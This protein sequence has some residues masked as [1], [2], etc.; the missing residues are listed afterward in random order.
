MTLLSLDMQL[1]GLSDGSL[2]SR[3]SVDVKVLD[4]DHNVKGKQ[5]GSLP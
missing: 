2:D 4:I 5:V 3:S 1:T